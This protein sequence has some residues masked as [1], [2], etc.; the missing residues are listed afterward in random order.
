EAKALY[1]KAAVAGDRDALRA[2]A[3]WRWQAGPE[4]DAEAEVVYRE[5]AA[6]GHPNV[7]SALAEWLGQRR[8]READA[9]AAY[10]E[11]AA[12][13]DQ[14]ALPALAKWLDARP[15]RKAEADLIRRLGLDAHGRTIEADSAEPITCDLPPRPGGAPDLPVPALREPG[16]HSGPQARP[17]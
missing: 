14:Y 1:R 12:A 17:I 16:R 9:E 7:L 5:V 2:L 10:R 6:D 3:W 8:G 11:A 4:A 13:G 15:G